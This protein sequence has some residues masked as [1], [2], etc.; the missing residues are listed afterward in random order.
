[1]LNGDYT[2][3]PNLN[4]HGTDT[5]TY[6]AYDQF[7]MSNIQTVTIAVGEVND[8]PV[9][10]GD[11]LYSIPEDTVLTVN[12]PGVLG[13]DSDS[14]NDPLTATIL[15]SPLNG[16]LVLNLDGSFVYT[17]DQDYFGLDGF[18]YRVSD[19]RGGSD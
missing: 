18:E 14:D 7:S 4:F 13:N 10:V 2:Y 11:G 5:F 17:P 19:G 15:I 8:P 3:T 9:A 1:N 12:T 16:N 6:Q